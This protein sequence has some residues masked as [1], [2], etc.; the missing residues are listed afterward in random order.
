MSEHSAGI[1]LFRFKNKKLEVLLVHPGGPFWAK[2][3][4]GVWSIPKGLFEENENPLD[5]ARREFK[6]E[7]GF[8]IDGEFIELGEVQQPERKVVHAWAFEK[9]I[10][11][12]KVVSNTFTLEWPKN[13]GRMQEYPEIDK[14][15]WFRLEEARV[16][17]LKGQVSFLKRLVERINYTHGVRNKKAM[18][19]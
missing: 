15:G 11:E 4:Q 19:P 10:D 2:K 3:D 14:A 13:S 8:E 18:T 17:I 9:D 1:L 6:E 12:T 5:V 16:K 7:T